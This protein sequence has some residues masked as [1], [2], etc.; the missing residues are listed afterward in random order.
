MSACGAW[1]ALGNLEGPQCQ[2]RTGGYGDTPFTLLW[3]LP[4]TAQSAQLDTD[5]N[6]R[7]RE[8]LLSEASNIASA[9]RDTAQAIIGELQV[10]ACVSPSVRACVRVC[11]RVC[12]RG[13]MGLLLGREAGSYN[14]A[15]SDAV[16]CCPR[17]C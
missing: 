3:D 10:C 11:G 7:L 12:G 6:R 9:V 17:V 5:M 13:T 8:G 1:Q 2:H 4:A 16:K 14:A 15:S